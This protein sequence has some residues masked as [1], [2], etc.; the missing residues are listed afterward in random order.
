M[1]LPVTLAILC[2]S[3]SHAFPGVVRRVD[4]E[5]TKWVPGSLVFCKQLK[6]QKQ[7]ETARLNARVASLSASYGVIQDPPMNAQRDRV[8]IAW[9]GDRSRSM[10]VGVKPKYLR[11]IP[12]LY[13]HSMGDY[14]R[15]SC[16][17]AEWVLASV[18]LSELWRASI[19][20][21]RYSSIDHLTLDQNKL[22]RTVR[23]VSKDDLRL[24][25]LI[26]GWYDHSYNSLK[27]SHV[28]VGTNID[29]FSKEN[30]M[31]LCPMMYEDNLWERESFGRLSKSGD[32]KLITPLL[33][34]QVH[35]VV[36]S[37]DE[38]KKLE[39]GI[40]RGCVVII[41]VSF[42]CIVTGF[43]LYHLPLLF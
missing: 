29:A 22:H 33:Q 16:N 24:L 28:V 43:M 4:P 9:L 8:N 30:L 14:D 20:F 11:P 27:D 19:R 6:A 39:S 12:R 31:R 26:E 17:N 21:T 5:C 35:F 34:R 23:G 42:A 2:F 36:H 41:Q 25:K 37:K 40:I 38:I 1:L 7:E 18:V 32:L 3:T 13:I 10:S 15:L